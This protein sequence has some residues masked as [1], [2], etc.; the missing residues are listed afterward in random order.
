MT[1]SR[2]AHVLAVRLGV[3]EWEWNIIDLDPSGAGG[4]LLPIP[5]SSSD[6]VICIWNRYEDNPPKKEH[7]QIPEDYNCICILQ[8]PSE[9]KMFKCLSPST[10]ILQIQGIYPHK[11]YS[12]SRDDGSYF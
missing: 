11:K 12:H 1:N 3:K 7:S 10:S 6:R 8:Q 2:T 4:R 5:L 9:I